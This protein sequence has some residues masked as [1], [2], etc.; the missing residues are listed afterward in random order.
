MPSFLLTSKSLFQL[1]FGGSEACSYLG[2]L[3]LIV[4]G[5]IFN[6]S[7]AFLILT[8]FLLFPGSANAQLA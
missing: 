4:G 6:F 8:G 5:G 2:T 7:C 1:C 3:F